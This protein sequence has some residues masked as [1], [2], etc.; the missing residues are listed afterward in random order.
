MFKAKYAYLLKDCGLV[1]CE[2]LGRLKI[3]R[4]R[5]MELIEKEILPCLEKLMKSQSQPKHNQ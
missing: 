1:M 2:R 4:F 3:Y 5:L